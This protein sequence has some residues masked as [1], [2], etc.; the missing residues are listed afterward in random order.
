MLSKLL[1]ED[2]LKGGKVNDKI[3]LEN[4]SDQIRGGINRETWDR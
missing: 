4:K 2:L 3:M 1:E